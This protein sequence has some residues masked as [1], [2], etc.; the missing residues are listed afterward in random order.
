MH[1][2]NCMNV[3]WIFRKF[4]IGRLQKFRE[5]LFFAEIWLTYWVRGDAEVCKSRRS[6]KMLKI[7]HFSLRSAPMHPWTT[8]MCMIHLYPWS[9]FLQ[10]DAKGGWTQIG[11]RYCRNDSKIQ[12]IAKRCDENVLHVRRRFQI[13]FR[14]FARYTTWQ[15]ERWFGHLTSP[16]TCAP[17][18]GHFQYQTTLQ[19][20]QYYSVVHCVLLLRSVRCVSCGSVEECR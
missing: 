15:C 8:Y 12:S 18:L 6:R 2:S 4:A 5:N 3:W 9:S 7:S 17:A 1:I 10:G 13:M 14:R 11:F 20:S 19:D 16:E